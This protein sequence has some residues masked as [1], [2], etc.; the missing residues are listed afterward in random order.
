MWFIILFKFSRSINYNFTIAE[1]STTISQTLGNE[2]NSFLNKGEAIDFASGSVGS[3]KINPKSSNNE[4][5]NLA[6]AVFN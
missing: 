6:N 2:F 5:R 4:F 1:V 3:N